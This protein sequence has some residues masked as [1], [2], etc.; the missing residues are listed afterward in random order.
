LSR[1]DCRQVLEQADRRLAL[2]L[3]FA[4]RQRLASCMPITKMARKTLTLSAVHD[5]G[6]VAARELKGP[7]S[8]CFLHYRDAPH[9][10]A[11]IDDR[12]A[13]VGVERQQIALISRDDQI[14]AGGERTSR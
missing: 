13:L 2:V 1:I 4:H 3:G 8:I 12:D 11:R 5:R 14:G 7:C 10:L 6:E 9:R